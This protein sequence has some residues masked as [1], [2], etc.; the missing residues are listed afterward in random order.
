MFHASC[1]MTILTHPNPLLRVKAKDIPQE[2]IND[3]KIT[4]LANGMIRAMYKARGVGLA[5]PQVGKDARLCIIGKDAIPI[6][7]DNTIREKNDLILINPIITER[8]VESAVMEEGCLSI[9][10][11]TVQV[12]RSVFIK[13]QTRIFGGEFREFNARDFFARV[14]QHELDHLDGVLIIDKTNTQ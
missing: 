7:F 9:P 3:K 10:G 1:L 8:S 11:I 14:I 2:K 13:V 4:R 5:A 6:E 12:E